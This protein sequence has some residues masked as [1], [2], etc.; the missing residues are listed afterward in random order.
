MTVSQ[1][2]SSLLGTW[3]MTSW[4]RQAVATGKVTDAMGADP[5]GYIAYHADGRMMA[6]VIGR[7]RPAPD[8][9]PTD[10]QKAALFDSMLAYSA[11]YTI[12]G[13][14]VTHHVDGSWNPAWGKAPLVRPFQLDGDSLV[15][16]G[17]PGRDPAT[18]EEV[19]YRMEFRKVP[20]PRGD[21]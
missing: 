10:A 13:N 11:S 21:A 19:V 12:E 8:G 15:I 20:T 17:A 5:L 7:D 6:L 14:T 4:T 18:G 9:P 1:A 3:K 2:E 16:S